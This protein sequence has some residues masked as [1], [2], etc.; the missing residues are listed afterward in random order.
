MDT[1]EMIRLRRKLRAEILKKLPPELQAEFHRLGKEIRQL[2]KMIMATAESRGD[3]KPA[4]KGFFDLPRIPLLRHKRTLIEF[5]LMH[6]EPATRKEI[7][8]GTDIPYGSLSSLLKADEFEQVSH[9]LWKLKKG[10]H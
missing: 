4:M 6:K 5:L 1:G 7:L 9:G 3:V 10:V 2:R 8:A